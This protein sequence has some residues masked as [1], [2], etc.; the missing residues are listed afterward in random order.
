VSFVYEPI[1]FI[2]GIY[3]FMNKQII[4]IGSGLGGLTC[5]YLL[6]KK[7]FRVSVVEKNQQAGGC[8]QTFERQGIRYETGMHYIGSMNEGEVLHRLFDYLDLL[9]DVTLSQLDPMAY[10]TISIGDRSFALANGS[11]RFVEELARHFP[12]ERENL[13]RYT[14]EMRSVVET[15][16]LYAEHYTESYLTHPAVRRSASGFIESIT[17]NRLLQCVLAGNNPLY[18]GVKD[19]TS[20]YIHSLVNDFYNRS[21]YRIVGGSD[22]LAQS[23][24]R[25]IRSMGGSVELG[26]PVVRINCRDTQAVSVSLATGEERAADYFISDIHPMRI[27]ELLPS[28]LVRKAYRER[29]AGLSN[30]S[31]NFSVYI[32]FKPDTI[33]YLNTNLYHYSSE[34][35]IWHERNCKAT[36]A[37]QSF[38]YMHLCPSPES[39]YARAAIVMTAM[40][41]EAVEAW[42]GTRVGRRGED[43]E[44]F[45]RQKAEEL[46]TLLE[47]RMPGTRAGI[48]RYYT[49]SP[50][51]YRDYT[52]TEKGS[53]YG[54]LHDCTDPLQTLIPVHTKVSNLFQTGQN[55]YYHGILGVIATSII[56]AGELL[57]DVPALFREVKGYGNR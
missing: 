48:T 52:G 5:G 35:D 9:P 49:S 38:L 31:G 43:Y 8:L 16:P 46:L 13:H 55:V 17:S 24:V 56:T 54:I 30:T 37:F 51:T 40:P 50:L 19:R 15:S 23:L 47:Q 57:G 7:G 2:S 26:L 33:P 53:A 6:A 25:S 4:I 11:E 39:R 28:S 34:A 41:Y 12:S 32:E 45:K 3:T 36:D 10:D 20:L 21:A 14:A 29:I 44:A 18:A 1:Y 27:I 42:S 22:C